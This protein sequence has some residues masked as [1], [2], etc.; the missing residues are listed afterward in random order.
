MII[1]STKYTLPLTRKEFSHPIEIKNTEY[2]LSFKPNKKDDSWYVSI[3]R[4]GRVLATSR[5][6]Y[7][8]PIFDGMSYERWDDT[9]KMIFVPY[10]NYDGKNP[11]VSRF[12]SDCYLLVV[13]QV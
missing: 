12:T 9:I 6:V 11:T 10:E 5:V 13:R 8:T 4:N 2:Q 7:L 1:N 3:I